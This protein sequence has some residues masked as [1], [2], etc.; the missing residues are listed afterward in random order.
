MNKSRA[1]ALLVA[2]SF[3]GC[4]AG[5]A[6]GSLA[7]SNG[8]LP[9]PARSDA[10]Q[11]LGKYIKHVVIIVQ[12][13]RT[14]D[15]IFL[16]YPGAESKRYGYM[17][18]GTR[19]KLHP[20]T[21]MG[22]DIVHGFLDA[23]EDFNGGKMNQFDFYGGTQ[24]RTYPYMY[25]KRNLVAPYWAMAQQYVLADHMFPT[26]FGPSFT[27][28]LTLVAGTAS[29]GPA[30]SEIDQPTE[31]PWGCDAPKGTVTSFV[32]ASGVR[33]YNKGPF[34]CFTQFRS[35]AD[36][37]DA[38]HVSWKFYTPSPADFGGKPWSPFASIRAVR[39]GPD[40]NSKVV[41]PET[42]VLKDA[43][44][45]RLPSVSWVAPDLA[46]SDHAGSNSSTG[47][48]WVASVVNAVG[49]S[50]DWKSTA[51]VVVWDDWGGWYD[52]LP[53]PKEDYRGLGIRVPC[54]IISP[55]ARKGYVSH[56]QYEFGSVLKFVEQAFGL[57]A[58][59][60]SGPGYGY[61]DGRANSL[62][63]SFDFT[64]PPRSFSP[65]PSAL[66]AQYFLNQTPSKGVP[67]ND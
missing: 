66:G 6:G 43:S 8:L 14:F 9:Q 56:T 36:T 15:N 20:G 11:P 67:D 17:H 29:L 25:L 22:P 58:L 31:N 33:T 62:V 26:M 38:A 64:K 51:I 47:P 41:S 2:L 42:K 28:H 30:R 34:P 49:K 18:D 1:L 65:I 10:A 21:F 27:A 55:Y 13:N 19:V 4:S 23:L 44:N 57:P 48:S 45:N 63:D 39:Y 12:E 32:S 50:P 16:G 40:W 59:S 54:L 7:Q 61:T 3:A 37:L 60:D 52:D 35:L 5:G 46:N 53:P 24:G